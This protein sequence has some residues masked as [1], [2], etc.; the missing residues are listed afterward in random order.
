M[1]ASFQTEIAEIK[2]YGR[3]LSIAI[4][5]KTNMLAFRAKY[6]I[7]AHSDYLRPAEANYLSSIIV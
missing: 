2:S 5:N 1:T 3:P 6:N 7:G 4:A